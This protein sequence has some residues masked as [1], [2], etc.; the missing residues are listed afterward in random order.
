[1]GPFK[2]YRASRGDRLA[3]LALCYPTALRA[4]RL[5]ALAMRTV[6][7]LRTEVNN[8]YT[9]V[10]DSSHSLINC[11]VRPL[12]GPTKQFRLITTFYHRLNTP[13]P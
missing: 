2:P 11:L 13:Y 9:S 3:T 12:F 10:G 7:V 5:A 8:A 6:Y 1:M 4:A